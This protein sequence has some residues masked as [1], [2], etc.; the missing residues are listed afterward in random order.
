MTEPE[1]ALRPARLLD[2]FRPHRLYTGLALRPTFVF[3]VMILVA[4]AV[5]YTQIALGPALRGRG[6]AQL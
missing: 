1:D 6:A 4:A 3:P 5:G 2:L